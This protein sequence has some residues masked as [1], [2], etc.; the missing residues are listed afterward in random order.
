MGTFGENKLFYHEYGS[1]MFLLSIG[2]TTRMHGITYQKT[3]FLILS[4]ART[5]HNGYLW[6]NETVLR[7]G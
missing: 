2:T 5:H 1:S 7:L 4:A 6:K 3:V